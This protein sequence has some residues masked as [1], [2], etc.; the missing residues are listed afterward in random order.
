MKITKA[1]VKNRSLDI[2][3]TDKKSIMNPEGE[4]LESSRDVNVKCSDLCHDSLLATFDLL[5]THGVMIADVRESLEVENAIRQ[6]IPINEIDP[7]NLKTISITG[8]VV[9]GSEEDGS[10]GAMIIFQKKNGTRILNITTPLV[11]FEDPDYPYCSEF[12]EVVESCIEEVEQYMEGKVAVKQLEMNFDEDFGGE[13]KIKE[14]KEPKKRGRKA[15]V[16]A[17]SNK[18]VEVT[19]SDHPTIEAQEVA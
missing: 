16:E 10:E 1:K 13:A 17:F 3:Y 2:D 5:K 4:V 11:K 19:F 14:P 15:K 8:F 18:E 9:S 7:E 12:R 6:G